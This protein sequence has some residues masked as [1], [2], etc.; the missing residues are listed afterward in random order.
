MIKEFKILTK[1]TKSTPTSITS[2]YMLHQWPH[3]ISMTKEPKIITKPIL[4]K[5]MWK[6]YFFSMKS[7]G[8]FQQIFGC[9]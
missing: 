5:Q 3:P 6:I 4:M 1:P 8:L 2:S 7:H 9:M